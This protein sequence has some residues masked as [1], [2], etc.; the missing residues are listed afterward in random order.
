MVSSGNSKVFVEGGGREA[1]EHFHYH[2]GHKALLAFSKRV[3]VE[4]DTPNLAYLPE[5]CLGS[6]AYFSGKEVVNLRNKTWNGNKNEKKSVT[7]THELTHALYSQISSP[8]AWNDSWG[9][10]TYKP[11]TAVNEGIAVLGVNMS[12]YALHCQN[13]MQFACRTLVAIEKL[14]LEE[15]TTPIKLYKALSNISGVSLEKRK[16]LRVRLDA[17]YHSNNLETRPFSGEDILKNLE[18]WRK[19]ANG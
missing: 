4:Y 17:I 19:Q 10:H 13:Y 1:F 5:N 2:Y 18:N 12:S 16:D 3:Q 8:T 11:E 9:R 6:C 14:A 7:V 15:E